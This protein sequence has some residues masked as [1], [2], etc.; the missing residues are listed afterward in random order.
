MFSKVEVLSVQLV[1]VSEIT[2]TAP[3]GS[4]PSPIKPGKVA[5]HL[6]GFIS[7]GSDSLARMNSL[8]QSCKSVE[9]DVMTYAY[10]STAVTGVQSKVSLLH[11]LAMYFFGIIISITVWN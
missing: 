1:I 5:F 11:T 3:A 4:L 8:F 7:C 9:S 6:A 2:V 10:I